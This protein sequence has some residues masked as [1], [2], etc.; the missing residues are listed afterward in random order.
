MISFWNTLP[1]PIVSLAPMEDVTDTSFREQVIRMSAPGTLHVMYTEF[2]STDGLCHERGFDK[3]AERL[4]VNSSERE[5]L[6]Q[7]GIRLVAQIWGSQPERF[8]RAA[9]MVSQTGRFDGIDINMGCPVKKVV[10]G[11]SC[12]AL[13]LDPTRAQDIIR[14]TRESTPLPVSVKTRV[15]FHQPVTE[16]WIRQLLE[17]GPSAIILHARTSKEQSLVA[18]DWSHVALAVKVRDAL[19]PDVPLLGNGD[20]SSMADGR[21]RCR[22]TGA[23]GFM[24][25]RGIFHDPWMFR[26][27]PYEPSRE[28]RLHALLSHARRY[29]QTWGPDRNFQVLKRF[30]KIYLHGF[31]GA[32]ALRATLMETNSLKEVEDAVGQSI[33]RMLD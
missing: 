30:F 27:S 21:A 32:A 9:E 6:Q 29:T 20:V 28:D 4:V 23:D 16:R 2:T 7:Q 33:N 19:A 13:I 14:A 1:R 22:E 26:D 31:P 12:S 11:G 5:L 18:A 8:A 15:G 25:G 24:V 3:V 10:K 17:A